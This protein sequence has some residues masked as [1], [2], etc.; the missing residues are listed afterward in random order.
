M[1]RHSSDGSQSVSMPLNAPNS[2]TIAPIPAI[3]PAASFAAIAEFF[4]LAREHKLCS[5]EEAV[6]RVTSK[7]AD[8]IGMTDRG[9]LQEGLVADIT[10][11]DPATIAPRATYL[12]PVQLA[13]GVQHVLV[14]GGVAM[15][16]GVQTDFRG[17]KFLRKQH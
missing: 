13:Q 5:I 15:E 11:F 16:N 14:G 10:V 12:E 17:G 4:R 9:R 1:A 7:A 8:M 3:P 6:R 2:S